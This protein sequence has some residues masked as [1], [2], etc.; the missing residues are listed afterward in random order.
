MATY[1]WR[2]GSGTWDTSSTT[3]WSTTSGGAGGFG[4]PTSADDV[5]FNSASSGGTYV[6]TCVNGVCKSITTAAPAAG[7]LTFDAFSSSYAFW[8][9]YGNINVHA[10]CLF[11][12]GG[13]TTA[14]AGMRQYV[15]GTAS[16]TFNSSGTNTRTII[17]ETRPLVS[18]SA[19]TFCNSST[20][21]FAAVFLTNYYSG[22]FNRLGTV[23]CT[24]STI[25]VANP[26]G[27]GTDDYFNIDVQTTITVTSS[28]FNFGVAAQSRATQS[29]D[30]DFDNAAGT[31]V[32]SPNVI[33]LSTYDYT[34]IR[35]KSNSGSIS[36]NFSLGTL[37]AAINVD[38]RILGWKT[39]GAISRPSGATGGLS[40]YSNGAVD[41]FTCTSVSADIY[42]PNTYPGIGT[43]FGSFSCSGA[44]TGT[45]DGYGLSV[46]A[47]TIGGT[48][49]LSAGKSFY[50]AYIAGSGKTITLAAI[51]SNGTEASPCSITS[52]IGGNTYNVSGSVSLSYTSI[53]NVAMTLTTTNGF[54]SNSSAPVSSIPVFSN[55]TLTNNGGGVSITNANWSSGGYRPNATRPTVW[56]MVNTVATA[57]SI[58]NQLNLDSSS[59]ILLTAGS[60]LTL[61]GISGTATTA[62]VT[63]VT[64]NITN[65]AWTITTA[66][67]S[68][69]ALTVSGGSL[70]GPPT[71]STATATAVTTTNATI[72][73]SYVDLTVSGAVSFTGDVAGT[74]SVTLNSLIGSSTVSF[75]NFQTQIRGISSLSPTHALKGTTLTVSNSALTNPNT[76]GSTFTVGGNANFYPTTFT[77]LATFNNVAVSLG[78]YDATSA[79]TFVGLTLVK[80]T[81]TNTFVYFTT[82]TTASVTNSIG[83][84]TATSGGTI[85]TNSYSLISSG[86]VT[87]TNVTFNCAGWTAAGNVAIASSPTSVTTTA[88]FGYF[89]N[90][91]SST[92]FTSYD[93]TLTGASPSG[94]SAGFAFYRTGD[95]VLDDT[96]RTTAGIFNASS[97]GVR[98]VT[99]A[100]VTTWTKKAVIVP[101]LTAFGTGGLTLTSTTSSDGALLT[102]SGT[103]AITGPFTLTNQKSNNYAL[104]CLGNLTVGGA[105]VANN[106]ASAAAN[107]YVYI[108]G[109]AT[110]TGTTTLTKVGLTGAAFTSTG[111]FSGTGEGSANNNADNTFILTGTFSSSGAITVANYYNVQLAALSAVSVSLT[112]ASQIVNASATGTVTNTSSVSAF[113]L[114]RVRLGGN[115]TNAFSAGILN[116]SASAAV[117]GFASVSAAAVNSNAGSGNFSCISGGA[118][119]LVGTVNLVNTHLWANGAIGSGAITHNGGG[120][121]GFSFTIDANA[122][123]CDNSS[124]NQA[125]SAAYPGISFGSFTLTN[126]TF[127]S[128]TS[129]LIYKRPLISC[130]QTASAASV[131]SIPL[132]TT[133]VFTNVDFWRIAPGGTSAKPWTGTSL[134]R[135]GG[136]IADLTTTASKSVYYVGGAG[137]WQDAKWAT[138]SGGTGSTA[139]YPLPQDNINFDANSGGG[140][141]T[142]PASIRIGSLFLAGT[143]PGLTQITP[144]AT[145]GSTINELWV[146]GNISGPS[147]YPGLGNLFY[148]G[149]SVYTSSYSVVFIDGLST[150]TITLTNGQNMCIGIYAK[151]Q[152]GNMGTLSLSE[153]LPANIIGTYEFSSYG[154]NNNLDYLTRIVN[155][156]DSTFSIST[157]GGAFYTAGG[158]F[159]FGNCAISASTI[160]IPSGTTVAIPATSYTWKPVSSY[161]I[162]STVLQAIGG[163]P[164]AHLGNLFYTINGSL[165]TF[166]SSIDDPTFLSVRVVDTNGITVTFRITSLGSTRRMY[167]LSTFIVTNTFSTFNFQN[168]TGDNITLNG[169]AGAQ[170]Q[171]T[172]IVIGSASNG[173]RVN[174]L[175][176][177]PATWYYSGG[178]LGA[179]QTG[180]NAGT[181]PAASTGLLFF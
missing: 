162:S 40:F 136:T 145:S 151:V 150:D 41:T 176:A 2:G 115:Y 34:Y 44:Y 110:I 155:F 79:F 74:K 139:N 29:M 131:F 127:I 129:S 56:S 23:T 123:P 92:M 38:G 179:G 3:N 24:S 133:R 124:L 142:F 144:L 167:T 99:G 106:S 85:S 166:S 16:C 86:A 73:F 45:F 138:S 46:G 72:D 91:S 25:S 17:F 105:F 148:L 88:S 32:G 121:D 43:G 95:L 128:C 134:G 141:I 36:A 140:E 10:A 33:Q 96:G 172:S 149:D 9:S 125:G 65:T 107:T 81:Y 175:P 42:F 35:A 120:I 8:D 135:V 69:G 37:T 30:W 27:A 60:T 66:G 161:S 122:V 77:G 152:Y 100:G 26:Y 171:W 168:T 51:T 71:D 97:G 21:T 112:H 114:T 75:T 28:T 103:V 180:W 6:V 22:S 1:Y 111:S 62:R 31:V 156:T 20:Q 119:T 159:N 53:S 146:T 177:S 14:F 48:L 170:N 76:T 98:F 50:D 181:A 113:T 7:T 102:A 117:Y 13:V 158:T 82:N 143:S 19:Y 164:A 39:T 78:G 108:T 132:A 174:V 165:T 94:A 55:F 64:T 80:G 70:T 58:A 178:S 18:G 90:G 52:Y 57:A 126:T 109:T 154:P 63:A 11:T 87:A 61:N 153:I 137:S 173:S 84:V 118:I 12:V 5:I 54:T 157:F 4:P 89:I 83:A 67:S 147:T 130:N 47:I 163:S 15:S 101:S 59:E 104:V 116:M 160:S 93:V 169:I 68:F 49:T